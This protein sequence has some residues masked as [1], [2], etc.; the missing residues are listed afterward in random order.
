MG[1]SHC[2]DGRFAA[3]SVDGCVDDLDLTLWSIT[4]V[5]SDSTKLVNYIH[6]IGD[7]AKDG[8][9]AIEMGCC[10]QGDEEPVKVSVSWLPVYLIHVHDYAQSRMTRLRRHT[11]CHWYLVQHWPC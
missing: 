10:C 8:V 4:A 5:C 2:R 6:A 7:T 1:I 11:G 3:R 9:L